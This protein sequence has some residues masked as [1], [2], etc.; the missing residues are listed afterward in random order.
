MGTSEQHKNM[1]IA[2]ID[3]YKRIPISS[4]GDWWTFQLLADLARNNSVSMFYT[5]EKSSEEGY[6]PKD[7]SFDTHF[8]PSRV[9]WSRVST[10]LDII[11]PDTLWDKAQIRD[12]E[13][14][15]VLTLVYGYHIAAS[16]ASKNEAPLVLVM[17]NVEWQYVKSIGSPLYLPIRMLENWILNRAD[18]V[19]TIS[20]RD[21]DYAV[22]YASRRVFY[23]PPQPDPHVFSPDGIRYDYGSDF[24]NVVFY[25]SLDRHQN[26]VALTFI[27]KE[28]VPALARER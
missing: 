12:I 26:R 10:W 17:H 24:F 5:S 6:L 27:T 14:D 9:K 3:I 28:L 25:G 11:R 8:L 21:C 19:I 1:K 23:I 15:C 22:K 20:P 7:I 13:A 16:I 18:A 4:G 2:F